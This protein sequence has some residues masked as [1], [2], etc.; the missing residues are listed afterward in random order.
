MIRSAGQYRSLV[1]GKKV[2]FFDFDGTIFPYTPE[3][4]DHCDDI[5]TRV[6]MQLVN[7]LSPDVQLSYEEAFQIKK[8]SLQ[9]YGVSY[10]AFCE[11]YGM[12]ATAWH[13]EYHDNLDRQ[14][15]AP[16]PLTPEDFQAFPGKVVIFSHADRGW[17]I[18]KSK[19][20]GLREVFPDDAILAF[21]D[22][23]YNPKS[24]GGEAYREALKKM[25]V[26]P[27]EAVLV[28]DSLLNHKSAKK[29]G[30][31]TV[32]IGY[33]KTVSQREHE[34]VDFSFHAPPEFCGAVKRAEIALRRQV[35]PNVLTFHR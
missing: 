7:K 11:L 2:Y 34:Y 31:T 5:G 18:D 4:Y 21:E 30:L 28:D 29:A 13:H 22:V 19:E 8:K 27:D 12:D 1:Q 26:S 24:N 17:L 33:G 16:S 32:H 9:K 3:F 23:G 14:L 15:T 6:A 35:K 25:D 10:M 20:F